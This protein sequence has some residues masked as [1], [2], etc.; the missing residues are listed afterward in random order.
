MFIKQ[1]SHRQCADHEEISAVIESHD[2][3]SPFTLFYHYFGDLPGRLHP[4]AEAF[5]AASLLVAMKK[6]EDIHTSEN[7]SKRFFYGL[8]Q[9]MDIFQTW[10]SESFRRITVRHGGISSASYNGD[11]IGCFFTL[12][13]D[14]FYTLLKNINT[15]SPG[16]R[17]T[18]LLLVQGIDIPLSNSSLFNDIFKR[19][20][21]VADYYALQIITIKTNIREFS[22]S[23]VDWY[24]YQGSGLASIALSLMPYFKKIYISSSDIYS[25]FE[26][27]GS[28]PLID[29]LWS[30]ESLEFIHDGCEA[31]RMNKILWQ[32]GGSSLALKHLR[33]CFMNAGDQYNCGKCEKCFRTMINLEI[34]GILNKCET[35]PAFLDYGKIK[36]MSAAFPRMKEYFADNILVLQ[37]EMN[38]EK[39]LEI[40][41]D[42]L[43]NPD[44]KEI[45][46]KYLETEIITIDRRCLHRFFMRIKKILM[47]R[48]YPEPP[49]K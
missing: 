44:D 28:H 25:T 35:L 3:T 38:N 48:M 14:S 10:H 27:I 13:V 6:G 19:I 33:V 39:L 49:C 42:S 34:A 43:R 4:L 7:I 15:A 17:I 22:D 20:M 1:V 11:K 41:V 18:H 40:L 5:I 31:S 9:I 24:T 37:R 32:V 23:I 2:G 47:E 45:K 26:P 16:E 30:T 29:P 12:G 46:K 21:E 36:E 8:D